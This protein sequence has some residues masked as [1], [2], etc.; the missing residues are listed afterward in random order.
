MR[1]LPDPGLPAYFAAAARG[2]WC[3]CKRGAVGLQQQFIFKRLYCAMLSCAGVLYWLRL[4]AGGVV[5]SSTINEAQQAVARCVCG[6]GKAQNLS[7]SRT[8]HAA[9]TM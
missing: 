5:D 7:C 8:W 3:M 4:D 2:V 9:H 6:A 1:V